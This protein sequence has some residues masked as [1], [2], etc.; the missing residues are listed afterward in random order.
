M[1]WYRMRQDLGG[2]LTGIF[3]IKVP[4]RNAT[5]ACGV[6]GYISERQCD[7][8][9]PERGPGPDGGGA[10]CD[11]WLCRYCATP[12]PGDRDLCPA[13]ERAYRTWLATRTNTTDGPG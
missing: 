9:M 1:P 6:C 2:L 11:R 13:H 4:R 3:H 7:W 5:P 10:R 12:Y 8:L